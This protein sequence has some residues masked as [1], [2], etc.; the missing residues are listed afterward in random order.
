LTSHFC[1]PELTWSHNSLHPDPDVRKQVHR[2]AVPQAFR[3]VK[4]LSETARQANSR[5]NLMARGKCRNR[6]SRNQDYLAS[7]E[8]NGPTEANTR[9]PNTQEKQDLD[10]KSHL[11]VMIRGL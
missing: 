5:D 1:L 4:P 6:S 11:M 8:S 9:Y 10:L 7:S 3:R 2:S